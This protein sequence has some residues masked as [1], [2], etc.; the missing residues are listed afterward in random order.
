MNPTIKTAA[1]WGLFIGVANM[2]W[3]YLAYYIG[4]HTSG[5]MVFQI[6]MLVWVVITIAGFI[7]ALRAIKRQNPALG[8]LAGVGAGAIAAIVSAL[9]AV[10][11]QVGYYRVI[12][13]AWPE[14]MAGQTREHFTAMGL[15][16]ADV[17]NMV[18]QARG[19]FTLTNYA[20]TSAAT[21]LIFGV[22]LSALIMLF[23]RRK[24]VAP[25]VITN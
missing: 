15:P 7:L 3:L 10:A 14:Y 20:I 16:P 9:V 13:P 6:F 24:S 19:T 17:D 21:A 1:K 22:V 18:E 12:H 11:A 23:L 8:Y 2:V 5:I 25:T 4:L